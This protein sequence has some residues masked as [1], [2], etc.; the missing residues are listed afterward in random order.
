MAGGGG[1]GVAPSSATMGM[2]S[3]VNWQH[4]QHQQQQR[5]QVNP[6]MHMNGNMYHNNNY[7]PQVRCLDVPAVSVIAI[8][9]NFSALLL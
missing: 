1:G 9:V 2:S 7:R 3:P 5:Q 6:R 8:R 4:Q